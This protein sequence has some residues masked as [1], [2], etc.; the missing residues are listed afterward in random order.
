MIVPNMR[1]R[2]TF[3]II[4]RIDIPWAIDITEKVAINIINDEKNIT[5]NSISNKIENNEEKNTDD[6]IIK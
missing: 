1:K 3:S 4:A 2:Y 5:D 6:F